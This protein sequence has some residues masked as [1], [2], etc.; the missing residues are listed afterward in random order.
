[1]IIFIST[2]HFNHIV[3]HILIYLSLLGN[4]PLFCL[5][6]VG[7]LPISTC[8]VPPPPSAPN[9]SHSVTRK[10]AAVCLIRWVRLSAPTAYCTVLS[11]GPRLKTAF[12]YKRVLPIQQSI[13]SIYSM[14]QSHVCLYMFNVCLIGNKYSYVLCLMSKNIFGCHKYCD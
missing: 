8:D 9:A 11:T 4:F 1:M 13:K 6:V 10:S 14:I 2:Y 3:I 7:W 12:S 5:C